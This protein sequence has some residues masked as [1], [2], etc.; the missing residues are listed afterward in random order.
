MASLP[1][2]LPPPPPP[3]HATGEFSN[4]RAHSNMFYGLRIH[5]EYYPA[6]NPCSVDPTNL[7][8]PF[9]QVQISLTA[10]MFVH[11]TGILAVPCT[12][13]PC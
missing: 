4:N 10:P 3:L 12:G 6:A 9:V 13:A 7:N 8:K 11:S 1:S 5:P 2:S